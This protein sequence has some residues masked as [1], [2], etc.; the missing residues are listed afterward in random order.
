MPAKHDVKC[1]RRRQRSANQ[2]LDICNQDRVTERLSAVTQ[3]PLNK[4]PP[5]IYSFDAPRPP[6]VQDLQRPAPLP[7]PT[8]NWH[9]WVALAN[10]PALNCALRKAPSVT[11]YATG[12]VGRG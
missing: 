2:I 12:V 9:N 3:N 7:F 10:S 5:A 1:G 6:M 8:I 4:H 11:P